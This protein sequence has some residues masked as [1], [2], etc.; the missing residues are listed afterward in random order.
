MLWFLKRSVPQ[1][2][3]AVHCVPRALVPCRRYAC[4]CVQRCLAY[5]QGIGYV[6][7][8]IVGNCTYHRGLCV[9]PWWEKRTIIGNMNYA[10][11]YA[12]FSVFCFCLLVV[13]CT[14]IDLLKEGVEIIV[15]CFVADAEALIRSTCIAS[16]VFFLFLFDLIFARLSLAVAKWRLHLTLL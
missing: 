9:D 4:I 14:V 16:C 12:T 11:L 13:C 5:S 15:R 3:N 7:A 2:Y 10:K 6:P 1:L 8:Q